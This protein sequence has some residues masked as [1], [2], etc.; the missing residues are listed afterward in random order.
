M[1]DGKKPRITVGIQIAE[2]VHFSKCIPIYSEATR[3][4]W[5]HGYDSYM[6]YGEFL[7]VTPAR[8]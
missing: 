7:S 8:G 3:K 1:D 2:L 6:K 5:T 4:L